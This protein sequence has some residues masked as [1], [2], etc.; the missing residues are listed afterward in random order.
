[1]CRHTHIR[2]LFACYQI[3]ADF[4]ARVKAENGEKNARIAVRH[5]PSGLWCGVKGRNIR[6]RADHTQARQ[7]CIGERHKPEPKR[8][9]GYLRVDTMHQDSSVPIG[10]A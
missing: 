1:L 7:V 10:L 2:L 9:P 8:N 6:L 3:L 4:E 5:L